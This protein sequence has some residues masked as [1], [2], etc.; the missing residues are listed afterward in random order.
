MTAASICTAWEPVEVSQ[1]GRQD[2]REKTDKHPAPTVR[3][4]FQISAM[5]LMRRNVSKQLPSG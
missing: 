2:F 1:T 4:A 5:T 3:A